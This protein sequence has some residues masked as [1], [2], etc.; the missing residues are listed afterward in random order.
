MD[1]A[2]PGARDGISYKVEPD[3]EHIYSVG[4]TDRNSVMSVNTQS[5]LIWLLDFNGFTQRS[6]VV[7]SVALEDLPEPPDID[8]VPS[9]ISTRA[10]SPTCR[11]CGRRASTT[12]RRWWHIC[13][14]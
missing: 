13:I 14:H 11:C 10:S 12:A 6:D 8:M 4:R 3:V 1:Q 2:A 5:N 7:A 9:T